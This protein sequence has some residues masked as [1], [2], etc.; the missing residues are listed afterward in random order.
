MPD[1]ACAAMTHTTL[2][3][4]D[5]TVSIK[6]APTCSSKPIFMVR[7]SPKRAPNQPPS[8]LVTTPKIS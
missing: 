6:S 5:G 4:A 8:K 1:S 2:S 7:F 3:A